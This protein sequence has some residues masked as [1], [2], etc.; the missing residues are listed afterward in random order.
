MISITTKVKLAG[1]IAAGA[2][3]LCV[4]GAAAAG[5]GSTTT[6]ASTPTSVTFTS[7]SGTTLKVDNLSTTAP[8]ST[9]LTFTNRGQCVSHFATSKAFALPSS[10]AGTKLSKNFHGKL[11]SSSDLKQF[12]SSF[13]ASE[14]TTAASPAESPEVEQPD[15][16]QSPEAEADNG[17]SGKG[18][19]HQHGHG[20]TGADD[21]G[22]ED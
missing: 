22:S 7:P 9:A 10:V 13:K 3:S 20:Q 16:T 17:S 11:M 21:N 12:C 18:K 4:V 2:L 8:S 1:A 15:A 14:P 19:A 5:G 6:L